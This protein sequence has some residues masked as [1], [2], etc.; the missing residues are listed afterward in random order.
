VVI[1]VRDCGVGI[2]SR[3]L[4]RLFERFYR[5]DVARSRQ[6]GGTGLGLAI[7]K[8]IARI[9]HGQVGVES[10]PARAAPSRSAYFGNR[11]SPNARPGCRNNFDAFFIFPL[12]RS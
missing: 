4:P 11:T 1:Q 12:T 6:N 8:H 2:D 5:V 3:H 10:V 9:H 7:V